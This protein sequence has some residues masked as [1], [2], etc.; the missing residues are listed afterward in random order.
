MGAAHIFVNDE[1]IA[2]ILRD[3]SPANMAKLAHVYEALFQRM[4]SSYEPGSENR[5]RIGFNE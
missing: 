1:E 4:I 2:D 5:R 3:S